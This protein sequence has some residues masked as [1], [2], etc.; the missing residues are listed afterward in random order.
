MSESPSPMSKRWAMGRWALLPSL[1]VVTACGL[2]VDDAERMVRAESFHEQGNYQAEIIELKNVLQNDPVNL[3]ARVRLGRASLVAGDAAS[4]VKEYRR[5]VELGADADEFRIPYALALLDAGDYAAVQD[6]VTS[7]T[8][9]DDA[10]RA[11]LAAFQAEALIALGELAPASAAVRQ[12]NEF[13]PGLVEVRLANAGLAM[14]E[15]RMADAA[16]I[17]NE[18]ETDASDLSRYWERRASLA[19]RMGDPSIAVAGYERAIEEASRL[20]FG[21]KAYLLQ[22]GLVDAMLAGGETARAQATADAMLKIAPEHPLP[23]FLS[24]R[25]AYQTGDM[26]MALSRVQAVLADHPASLPANILAG[27]AALQLGQ[28]AQAE[29]YFQAAVEADP[30]SPVARKLLAQ[31]RLQRGEGDEALEALI[32][33]FENNAGDAELLGLVGVASVQ[34]GDPEEAIALY[35]QLLERD[36]DN[37]E[38]RLYLAAALVAAGR[39]SEAQSELAVMTGQ[40]KD[41]ARRAALLSVFGFLKDR[42]FEGGRRAADEILSRPG[43]NTETMVLLG[44]LFGSAGSNEDA[45]RYLTAALRADP[46]SLDARLA[47]AEVDVLDG[48][49]LA[50]RRRYTDVIIDDPKNTRAFVGLAALAEKEGSTTA[51]IEWLQRARAADPA[52]T[53]PRLRLAELFLED[54]DLE[55]AGLVLAEAAAT[56]S[57]DY[58]VRNL[59][60]IY[61]AGTGDMTAARDAF[62]AAA[63]LAPGV[64]A[65]YF[66][67]G[68]AEL[69]LGNRAAG[70]AALNS[71]LRVDPAY[72]NARILLTELA[73]ARGDLGAAEAELARLAE[74]APDGEAARFL[75]ADLRLAQERFPEAIS[76]YRGLLGDTDSLR[77]AFGLYRARRQAGDPLALDDLKSWIRTNSGNDDALVLLAQEQQRSGSLNEAIGTYEAAV[78]AAPENAAALNNLAWLYQESGDPRALETAERAY[79]LMPESGPVADTLGWI[80]FKNGNRID[81]LKYLT[82]A[83]E[84]APAEPDIRYHLA[85]VYAE[86]GEVDRARDELEVILA[87]EEAVALHDEAQALLQSL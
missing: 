25:V 14:A 60:G 46:G 85:T 70:L 36:P 63:G 82:K 17:L 52:S 62:S 48:H 80:H 49:L 72:L 24:A 71:A 23:N 58:R 26:P 22:A 13:S 87:S 45:R 61:L 76:L 7:G 57:E 68:R 73:V 51:A 38:A 79:R 9:V 41:T 42:D 12:A 83:V 59:Q 84:L 77:A 8:A 34:A 4:A 30:A 33:A 2:A 44:R 43:T 5:A 86:A 37:T 3:E 69:A 78:D 47:L 1:L 81:A 31:I 32:P 75:E 16:S 64:A 21:M 40:D 66:N 65:T 18:L 29:S 35:R 10:E 74:L 55:S 50:A 19:L 11:R 56:D 28:L 67:L 54:G 20:T 15:G 53:G 6:V 39:N 27:A